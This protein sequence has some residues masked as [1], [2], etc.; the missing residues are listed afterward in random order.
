MGT[1]TYALGMVEVDR[2]ENG[3]GTTACS[4]VLASHPNEHSNSIESV[5]FS[6]KIAQ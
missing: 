1:M 6:K 2:N 3:S 5:H 4:P